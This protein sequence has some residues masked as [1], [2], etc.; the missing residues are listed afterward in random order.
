MRI[1][2]HHHFW[3]PATR[4]YPWMAGKQLDPVRRAYRPVDLAGELAEAGIGVTVLVQTVSSEHETREFLQV[5]QESRRTA[6]STQRQM[7]DRDPPPGP[8][9]A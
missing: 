6:R 2:A 1:D 4:D 9:R 5:A 7:A 3:D 8:R